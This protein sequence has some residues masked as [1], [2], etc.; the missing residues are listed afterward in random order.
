MDQDLWDAI[1]DGMSL[2]DLQR[3]SAKAINTMKADNNSIHNTGLLHFQ[4]AVCSLFLLE[5]GCLSK[6]E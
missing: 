5:I 6:V 2:R 1:L 4:F 3:E